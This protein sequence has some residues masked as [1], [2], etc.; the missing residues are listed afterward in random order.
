MKNETFLFP[1][2]VSSCR[3]QF[4]SQRAQKDAILI[5]PQSTLQPKKCLSFWFKARMLQVNVHMKNDIGS[6]LHQT[7]PNTYDAVMI[8]LPAG[9]MRI[10]FST[11]NSAFI[12]NILLKEGTCNKGTGQGNI[13]LSIYIWPCITLKGQYFL[14]KTSH[15]EVF[16]L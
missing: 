7:N 13:A 1:G 16:L 8:N 12:K 3:I 10:S 9:D 2:Q 6:V 14:S 4:E 15:C 5:S 11:M